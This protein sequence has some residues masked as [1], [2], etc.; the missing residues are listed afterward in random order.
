MQAPQESL[1]LTNSP[2]DSDGKPSLGIT[3]LDL[4]KLSLLHLAFCVSGQK[5][6]IPDLQQ[7]GWNLEENGQWNLV[8]IPPQLCPILLP[9]LFPASL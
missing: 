3:G 5:V 4:L 2:A 1:F 6:L 7:R 9:A 8:S